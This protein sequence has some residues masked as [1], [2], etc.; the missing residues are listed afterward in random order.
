MYTHMHIQKRDTHTY[1]YHIYLISINIY[2]VR[3]DAEEPP[4]G[5]LGREGRGEGGEGGGRRG[6]VAGD[7]AVGVSLGGGV[8]GRWGVTYESHTT[9]ERCG[10]I[11]S[12]STFLNGV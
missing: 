9:E 3:D 7:A 4:Q 10:L 11:H 1:I 2:L 8:L 5:R 6:A 12:T